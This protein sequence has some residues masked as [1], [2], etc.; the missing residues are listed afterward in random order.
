MNESGSLTTATRPRVRRWRRGAAQAPQYVALL[1]VTFVFLFPLLYLLNVALKTPQS[2]LFDPTGFTKSLDFANFSDAWTRGNFA[3]Y[4]GNT[5]LYTVCAT[6]IGVLSS[7][8]VALPISRGYVRWSNVWY[9]LF[10]VSLFLPSG[11][12]PQF[13]LILHLHLYN[14]QLGYILVT[15]GLGIGP[16]MII[17]YLRSIPRELDEAASI[18]GCGYLRYNLLMLPPLIKPILVTAALLQAIGVWN[19][20]IGPTIYLSS[21]GYFPVALGLFT[22]YG[23]YGND[24][25]VLAAAVLIVAAPLVALFI[26]LQR[27]FMEGA[28]AGAIK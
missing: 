19:D 9:T 3:H 23:Q 11:L 5:I 7:L 10:V 16:F 24:W 22:F 1:L 4:F 14:T 17:G 2:Y 27:Y 26:F 12:I 13:Q 18:D 25:T 21:P 8:L 15:S 6:A 28:T 20:I